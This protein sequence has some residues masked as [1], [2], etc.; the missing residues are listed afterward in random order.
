MR[1]RGLA[2]KTCV[3]AGAFPS[4]EHLRQR[5]ALDRAE[6]GLVEDEGPARVVID[7]L[8][9][10]AIERASRTAKPSWGECTDQPGRGRL[11]GDR[12]PLCLRSVD[13]TAGQRLDAGPAE[14]ARGSQVRGDRVDAG[15]ADLGR[16]THRVSNHS[17]V[18]VVTSPR[19]SRPGLGARPNVASP[20][21]PSFD[22][23]C[24]D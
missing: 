16:L 1:V 18:V 21:D 12:D 13:H 4:V 5:I 20:V 19:R 23:A 11:T 7:R 22:T 9:D 8:R 14:P 6:R 17:P 2:C 10:L 3:P 15:V 24:S